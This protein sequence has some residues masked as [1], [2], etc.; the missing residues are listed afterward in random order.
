MDSSSSRFT[1]HTSITIHGTF[2]SKSRL[3]FWGPGRTTKPHLDTERAQRHKDGS[4][5]KNLLSFRLHIFKVLGPF[6]D[7]KGYYY[8]S[9]R[10]T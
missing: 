9:C 6:Q 8:N 1:E 7:G 3:T 10:L 5:V 2:S 4:K